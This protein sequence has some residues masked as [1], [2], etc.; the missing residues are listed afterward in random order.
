MMQG[1]SGLC[2]IINA[3]RVGSFQRI[4]VPRAQVVAWKRY[5]KILHHRCQVLRQLAQQVLIRNL[6]TGSLE[7]FLFT[8]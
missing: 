7:I 5:L 2:P 1:K 3:I 4:F 6:K 8:N